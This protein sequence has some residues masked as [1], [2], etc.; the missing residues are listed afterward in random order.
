MK[1]VDLQISVRRSQDVGRTLHL[2]DRASEGA[3]Q[4]MA[5]GFKKSLEKR[6]AAVNQA[7]HAWSGR[8]EQGE[9]SGGGAAGHEAGRERQRSK[10]RPTEPGKDPDK[11]RMLDV[12]VGFLSE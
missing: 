12:T 2:R 3:L 6:Q 11:G 9:S 10:D 7:N 8:L 1:P 5:A 4:A